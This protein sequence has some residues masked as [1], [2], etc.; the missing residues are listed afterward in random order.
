MHLWDLDIEKVFKDLFNNYSGVGKKYVTITN[1][2][3]E[4]FYPEFLQKEMGKSP[5][6]YKHKKPLRILRINTDTNSESNDKIDLS[7]IQ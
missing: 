7:V 2:L 5:K 1:L 3:L 4:V 6:Q